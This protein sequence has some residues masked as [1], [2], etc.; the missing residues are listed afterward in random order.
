M[1]LSKRPH[2]TTIAL[3]GIAA[4]AP[5]AATAAPDVPPQRPI[6]GAPIC[7]P[8]APEPGSV[9]FTASPTKV[10][11]GTTPRLRYTITNVGKT[12]LGVSAA[13]Y[14]L[15]QSGFAG[16]SEVPWDKGIIT[17]EIRTLRPGQTIRGT[18]APLPSFLGSGGFY[19]LVPTFIPDAPEPVAAVPIDVV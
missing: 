4:T 14:A 19:Q 15:R 16:W 9:K 13:P 17:Q 1:R 7:A 11:Q 5:A 10:R 6:I 18:T 8:T 12:C 3:L 2:L